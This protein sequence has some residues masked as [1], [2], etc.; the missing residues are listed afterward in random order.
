[1]ALEG[2]RAVPRTS[3]PDYAVSI[4]AMRAHDRVHVV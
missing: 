1:M 4:S 3:S 2:A